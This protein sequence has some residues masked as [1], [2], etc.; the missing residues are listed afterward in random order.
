VINKGL[1]PLFIYA[2][3]FCLAPLKNCPQVSGIQFREK[4]LF[5]FFNL[6]PRSE[7]LPQGGKVDPQG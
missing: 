6:A 2:E 1:V 3:S 4:N 7:I 5:E